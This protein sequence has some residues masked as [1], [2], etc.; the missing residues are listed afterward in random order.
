MNDPNEVKNNM[1]VK[2]ISLG[3]TRG[4]MINP[5][6]T[7]CRAVGRTGAVRGYVPGHG[8]DVW[9]VEHADGTVGAY[10]YDEFERE[11]KEGGK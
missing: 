2:I 6:H 11:Y 10:V 9:W 8:G 7:E 3:D 4:M 1:R 5:K